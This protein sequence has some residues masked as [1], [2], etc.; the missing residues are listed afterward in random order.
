MEIQKNNEIDWNQSDYYVIGVGESV[1]PV[2]ACMEKKNY[3]SCQI[4]WLDNLKEIKIPSFKFIIFILDSVDALIIDRL[5]EF[6]DAGNII[7]ICH[8][9]NDENNII[10]Y[11][12]KLMISADSKPYFYEIEAFLDVLFKPFY[13]GIGYIDFLHFFT[14]AKKLKIE[15]YVI[16]DREE[17]SFVGFN[18][19]IT[20]LFY[21]IPEEEYKILITSINSK[22]PI[23]SNCILNKK[24]NQYESWLWINKKMDTLRLY[25]TDSAIDEEKIEIVFLFIG[26]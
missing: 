19:F 23:N 24:Y 4:L 25:R 12:C 8:L 7:V 1:T 26:K 6:Y 22:K 18:N 2:L 21:E 13:M 16:P 11:D 3:E 10:K 15:K 14:N 17:K 5:E 20:G 9:N